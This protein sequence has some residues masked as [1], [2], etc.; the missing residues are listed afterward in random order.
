MGDIITLTFARVLLSLATANDKKTPSD[1]PTRTM[2]HALTVPTMSLLAYLERIVE[3]ANCTIDVL[4]FAMIYM[5][6]LNIIHPKIFNSHSMHRIVLTS[7]MLASKFLDDLHLDNESFAKCGGVSNKEINDLE[8]E[9]LFVLEFELAVSEK[10]EK[11]S[12]ED[13][14]KCSSVILRSATGSPRSVATK[15]SKLNRN[16]KPYVPKQMQ[17]V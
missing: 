9:L 11:Q 7:V 12:M 6:R 14:H 16:A 4:I 15:K 8:V 5:D 2:F 13:F 10:A 1:P 17:S 3:H